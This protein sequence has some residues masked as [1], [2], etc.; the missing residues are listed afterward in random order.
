M[1]HNSSNRHKMRGKGL[2]K[3]IYASPSG[4][5][6]AKHMIRVSKL[7]QDKQTD[8]QNAVGGDSIHKHN[9]HRLIKNA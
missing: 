1:S 7:K 8:G 2:H 5:P 9:L 4:I 3:H 6:Q